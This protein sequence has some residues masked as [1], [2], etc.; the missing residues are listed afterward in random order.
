MARSASTPADL[1]S[2]IGTAPLPKPRARR[3]RD[4]PPV[5]IEGLETFAALTAVA[6][7]IKDGFLATERAALDEQIYAY[8]I[9]NGIALG[10][11]PPN[12][13]GAAPHV[14]A[15]L[16]LRIRTPASPLSEEE[17]EKLKELDLPVEQVTTQEHT[18]RLKPDV[19]KNNPELVAKMLETLHQAGFKL[20]ELFEEQQEQSAP[21][22][23]P[24]VFDELFAKARAAQGK[25]GNR[26][27]PDQ[28]RE[29]LA[30]CG[31][32]G[33]RADWK[34][35]IGEAFQVCEALMDAPIEAQTQTTTPGPFP[36]DLHDVL[37][38]GR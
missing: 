25:R 8:F 9:E 31:V 33:V 34:G 2:L 13:K 23:A 36:N 15:S 6:K 28:I 24:N 7:E 30:I 17:V 16:Q 35:T 21:V 22:A 5:A 38:G 1:A 10:R 11:C 20:G 14:T 12:F 32:T 3:E 19:F 18:Y 29:V 4:I 37:Q 27:T 26:F